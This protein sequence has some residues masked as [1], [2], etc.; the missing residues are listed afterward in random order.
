MSIS[1][2]SSQIYEANGRK[3][4]PHLHPIDKDSSSYFCF[5]VIICAQ[6]ASPE[7]KH[8]RCG[9]AADDALTGVSLSEGYG[10][11]GRSYRVCQW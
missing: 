11:T 2:T 8:R 1:I 5:V 4:L 6:N 10:T 3:F 9:N 7:P